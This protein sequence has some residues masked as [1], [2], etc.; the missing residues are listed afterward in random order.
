MK[1]HIKHFRKKKRITQDQ[2]AKNVGISRRTLVSIE[3]G[4]NNLTL[5]LAYDIAAI[6]DSNIYELFEF[7]K[8]DE[9]EEKSHLRYIG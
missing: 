4:A 7:K 5:K 3:K 9:K 6:L 8:E 1:N 2:L